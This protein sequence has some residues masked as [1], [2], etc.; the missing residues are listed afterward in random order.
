MFLEHG[1]G[2]ESEM[3]PGVIFTSFA[4]N[5]CF[6]RRLRRFWSEMTPGVIFQQG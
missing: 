1:E 6:D 3:T 4:R 5:I 2:A